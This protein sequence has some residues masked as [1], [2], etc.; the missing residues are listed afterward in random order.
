MAYYSILDPETYHLC[1]NCPTGNNIEA[2][3][4]RA[5]QMDVASLCKDCAKLRDKGSCTPGIPTPAG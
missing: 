1:K 2:E 5:G 4:L 3:N